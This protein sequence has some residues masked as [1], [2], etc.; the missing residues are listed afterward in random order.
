MEMGTKM[1]FKGSG[2]SQ[3]P[4]AIVTSTAKKSLRSTKCC[5]LQVLADY[6]LLCTTVTN[7]CSEGKPM[8]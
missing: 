1:S 3:F 8:L 5:S 2:C 7:A 4:E 6:K